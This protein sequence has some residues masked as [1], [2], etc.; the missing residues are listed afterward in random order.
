MSSFSLARFSAVFFK[1]FVQMRRDRLTFAIMI[2]VPVMQLV[3]FGYAINTDPRHMALVVVARETSSFQRSLLASLKAS[4]F[5][6]IV[7]ETSDAGVAEAMMQ[8]GRTSFILEIPAGFEERLVAGK[9]PQLLLAADATDPVASGGALGAIDRIAQSAFAPHFV[10]ALQ[11]LATPALP[12]DLVV[13]RRYNPAGATA[14]NIV[15]GLLGIILTMTLVMMSSIGLTREAERGTLETLLSTPVRPLEVMIGKTTPYIFIGAIQIAIVLLAARL[16][17]GVPFEGPAIALFAGLALFVAVNLILGFLISTAAKSQLQAV[18]MT[19]FLFLPSILL[20][21][22]MFPFRAMPVWA[23][24]IGEGLPITH[25][26]RIVREVMLKG[27]GPA[28]IAGDLWPLAVML[29]VLA[30]VALVRYRRTL[31]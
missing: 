6:D 18:Q 5:F 23:R 10:G 20:S 25:F 30:A 21:G 12:Y 4:S 24:G 2:M 19:F 14:L 26:L 13:Q 3:L 16:L 8:A 7:G 9:R 11:F 31:D 27:A 1:E 22:F 29:V 28:E 15:P 17:F